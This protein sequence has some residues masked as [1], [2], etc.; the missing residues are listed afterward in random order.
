[1]EKNKTVSRKKN[2]IDD[3]G[4]CNKRFNKAGMDIA[5]YKKRNKIKTQA[6]SKEGF[7]MNITKNQIDIAIKIRA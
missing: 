4:N 7:M 5:C 2:V 1:M 3:Y 6:V